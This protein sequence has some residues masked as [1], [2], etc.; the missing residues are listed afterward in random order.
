MYVLHF[1]KLRHFTG[2]LVD[3]AKS[4][5]F[6]SYDTIN[7]C[8]IGDIFRSIIVFNTIE[9]AKKALSTFKGDFTYF[10]IDDNP[11]FSSNV[12]IYKVNF[13]K[14]ETINISE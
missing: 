1:T 13:T 10:D 14:E 11:M 4:D 7:G 5:F 12:D 2:E 8:H 3:K 6:A 9:E